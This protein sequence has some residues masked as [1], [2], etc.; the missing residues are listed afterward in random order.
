MPLHVVAMTVLSF[1]LTVLLILKCRPLAESLKLMDIPG[2]RKKHA[3]PTPLVGG[4][5]ILFVIAPITIIYTVVFPYYFQNAIFVITT[6]GVLISVLAMIDDRVHISPIIRLLVSTTMF[7]VAMWWIPGLQ[8]GIISWNGGTSSFSLGQFT[9]LLTILSLVVLIN[10]INMA[11]GKNGLVTGLC[12]GFFLILLVSARSNLAPILAI[13]TGVTFALLVFNLQGKIFLGDG[14]SYGLA[15]LVGLFS[16]YIY[17]RSDLLI[18]ADQVGLMFSVPVA[19]MVRLMIVRMRAGRSPFEADR[20]HLH[21]LLQGW[22]GWKRGLFLYWVL[23]FVPTIAA[24]ILPW[25]TWLFILV[26]IAAYCAVIYCVK[27]VDLSA[28]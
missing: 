12:F 13:P 11:D 28:G 16:I 9:I 18:S 15:A 1:L 4:L 17:Q 5:A 6:V 27:N 25:L 19:D 7:G 21:H 14:G 2:G 10:A 22:V 8:I 26:A 24:L 20:N 23:V 3:H